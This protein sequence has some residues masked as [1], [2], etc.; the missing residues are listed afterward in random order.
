[1]PEPEESDGTHDGDTPKNQE[2]ENQKNNVLSL[3]K[4][5]TFWWEQLWPRLNVYYATN[6]SSTSSLLLHISVDIL[7]DVV[8]EDVLYDTTL[9]D[10]LTTQQLQTLQDSVNDQIWQARGGWFA[11]FG[12]Y[13]GYALGIIDIFAA[14]I[15][16]PGTLQVFTVA[17][18]LWCAAFGIWIWWIY[19][20][21]NQGL[22]SAIQAC[23]WIANFNESFVF[24]ITG[25][26]IFWAGALW[27]GKTYDDFPDLFMNNGGLK[28]YWSI[29]LIALKFGVFIVCSYMYSKF[30]EQALIEVG[31]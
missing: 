3:I 10:D 28:G 13:L 16:A 17:I 12:R 14:I 31:V 9:D 27:L 30:Y 22:L 11:A 24:S 18:T 25:A 19:E 21:F 2:S 1:M 7:G 8:V 29:L 26:A 20:Y 6:P 4:N 23:A 5:M 15:L